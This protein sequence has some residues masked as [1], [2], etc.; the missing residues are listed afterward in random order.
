MA[1]HKNHKIEMRMEM[2]PP[3]SGIF[4]LLSHR[5]L[6]LRRGVL[7]FAEVQFVSPRTYPIFSQP[8]FIVIAN[9]PCTLIA[10]I[11]RRGEYCSAFPC[12]TA[13]R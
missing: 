13:V 12:L 5:Y 8:F 3:Y 7:L 6:R 4:I 9:V 2:M 11:F 10:L 1:E